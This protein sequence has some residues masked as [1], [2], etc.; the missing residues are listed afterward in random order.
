[1]QTNMTFCGQ[2]VTVHSPFSSDL[3]PWSIWAKKGTGGDPPPLRVTLSPFFTVFFYCGASLN[4]DCWPWMNNTNASMTMTW[5]E[6]EWS[7]IHTIHIGRVRGV[8]R[9]PREDTKGKKDPTDQQWLLRSCSNC[10]VYQNST[11]YQLCLVD[12]VFVFV[13][14]FKYIVST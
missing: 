13:S 3:R 4:N 5:N 8:K 2:F 9:T 6:W 14:T 7:A 12:T 1:M 11:L 10:T